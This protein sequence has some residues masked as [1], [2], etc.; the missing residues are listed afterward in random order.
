MQASLY[1]LELDSIKFYVWNWKYSYKIW[2]VETGNIAVEEDD[3]GKTERK[4]S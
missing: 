2:P 1:R 4:K 3:S